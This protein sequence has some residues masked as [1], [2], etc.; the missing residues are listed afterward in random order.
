LQC[1]FIKSAFRGTVTTIHCFLSTSNTF[2]IF[3]SQTIALSSLGRGFVSE[4]FQW[5]QN[6]RL[7]ERKAA[8]EQIEG[9][10]DAEIL[11][12]RLRNISWSGVNEGTYG[13]SRRTGR[14]RMTFLTLRL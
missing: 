1:T 9:L 3:F 11:F 2:D 4:K 8:W 10:P 7:G 6:F 12:P 14:K 5:K 13:S